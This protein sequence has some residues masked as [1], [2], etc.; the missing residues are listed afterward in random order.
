[1]FELHESS[2]PQLT[3]ID[4]G[5]AI[6][7]VEDLMVNPSTGDQMVQFRRIIEELEKM[8]IDYDEYF[9]EHDLLTDSEYTWEFD[10]DDPSYLNYEDVDPEDLDFGDEDER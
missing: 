5:I 4:H 10:P 8:A 2:L 6:Y 3:G 9:A 7:T 1:M